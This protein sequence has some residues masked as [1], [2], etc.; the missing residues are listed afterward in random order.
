M[1]G[2]ARRWQPMSRVQFVELERG[3]RLQDRQGQLRTVRPAPYLE[4]GEYRVV[5]NAGDQVLIERERYADSYML[6]PGQDHVLGLSQRAGNDELLEWTGLAALDATD[7]SEQL[8]MLFDVE[9]ER[10]RA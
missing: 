3:Q 5:L 4:A 6:R 2:E 1:G 7:V 9:A 8:G 10:R